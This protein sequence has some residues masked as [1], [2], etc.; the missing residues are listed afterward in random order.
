VT[1]AATTAPES[2]ASA[3]SWGAIIAGAAESSEFEEITDIP[4][5]YRKKSMRIMMI[6]IGIPKNQ[7]R[8][9]RPM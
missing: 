4:F 1:A 6:G 3:V 8:I 9:P 7:S 5:S 2:S